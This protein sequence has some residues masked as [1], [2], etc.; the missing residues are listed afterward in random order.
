MENI[1]SFF[2]PFFKESIVVFKKSC[3]FAPHLRNQHAQMAESHLRRYKNDW[4]L[5][6]IEG[7]PNDDFVLGYDYHNCGICNLCRD[8]GCFELAKYLCRMDFVLAD[9]M[10]LKLTRTQTLAENGAYCD[11]RY[12]RK[13]Q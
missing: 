3:I 8:E 11:F 13:S 10:D 9:M 12:G 6:I 2:S 7:G 1:F 5:D 4:V